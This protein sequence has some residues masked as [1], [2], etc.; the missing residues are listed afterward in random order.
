MRV[1]SL[2]ALLV[3][4]TS[5]AMI[6]SLG[7]SSGALGALG[8]R[9][10]KTKS[11]P[12]TFVT[13][14]M[15][16]WL[17]D[18]STQ[19]VV[20]HANLFDDASPFVF[21][22]RSATA[23][24]LQLSPS[25]WQQMRAD[26]RKAGVADIPTLTADLNAD[27]FASLLSDRSRRAAHVRTL[28]RLASRYHVDGIDLDYESIN[29]G[30]AT[31]KQT[32]RKLYPLF[33]DRLEQ[34][35]QANGQLLS[36]TV[37]A[38][39]SRTDPNWYVYDYARLGAAADR[40][41]IMTY[42]YHWSGGLPGPMAPKS[43]VSDVLRY[44]TSEVKASKISFGV[45][46][47]GRDWFGKTVS[48]RC[49]ASA[50][51]SISRTTRA[52]QALAVS[53]HVKPRWSKPGTSKTF[54]YRMHY[55]G[56]GRSCVAKRVV[57]FDD[58]RSTAA[59]LPLVQRYQIRGVAMWALG[60]ESGGTWARLD[61]FGHRVARAAPS[62]AV[63]APDTVAFGVPTVVRAKVTKD[64]VPARAVKATL[65]RRP[66]GGTDWVR[67][68]SQLTGDDGR[69]TFRVSPRRPMQWRVGTGAGWALLPHTTA[70]TSTRVTY[71][72]NVR[73]PQHVTPRQARWTL[74]GTAT[75]PSRR[76]QA[77]R[78]ELIDG[79]WVSG[80]S[81]PV[82]ADGSFAFSLRSPGRGKHVYRVVARSGQ[83]DR[84]VS[85]RVSVKVG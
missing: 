31:A 9:G 16:Y 74:R 33:V 55:S 39:T 45:P 38:R 49:P 20:R 30:S 72:V 82:S 81:V 28:V 66:V 13:G 2:S 15:P 63:S 26:L 14:W 4:V 25:A 37:P 84:G 6:V 27:Q 50:H 24:D 1:R 71:A 54:T 12:R 42:D 76:T 61:D 17:A 65:E 41:R 77:V 47:Y 46:A 58:A 7:P 59:K 56:G 3:V 85:G 51:A 19:S 64:R 62:V 48:G 29:F 8:A 78:Q 36:V 18:T 68:A 44:A 11:A 10:E 35:L 43:W 60:Y 80:R 40:L 22:V 23:V 53:Q 73:P 34:R 70:P 52:M 75:Q 83:L 32:V 69:V 79:K 5:L 57:W 67:V 21:Q